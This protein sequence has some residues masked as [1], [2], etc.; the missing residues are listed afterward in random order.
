MTYLALYRAWRPQLFDDVIG[1]EHINQTLRNALREQRF[2]HAYLFNGPRGT[3]KTSTAKIFA[4]AVN[5]ELGPREEPCNQCNTCKGITD[6]SIMDVVEIDAAS[7][8]G[9]EEIR[10]L[11]EKVKFAPTEV[12]YKVY[13]IDEV[14]M[15]TTEA[16]NALLKTLEE[17]PAHVI[18]I[19]ATTEPH[20]LPLTIISRCQRFDFR[21]ISLE[22]IAERLTY[23]AGVEGFDV[24][25]DAITLVAKHSE[26][27]MRD[28]LSLL[29]QVL[30]FSGNKIET[31]DVLRVTGRVSQQ[32][33]SQLVS[34]IYEGNLELTLNTISEFVKQGKEPEKILEDMLY[35]YRDLLL[36]KSAPELEEIK[37]KV[38]ADPDFAVIAKQYDEGYIYQIIET[39]NH[40]LNEMKYASQPRILL[41]LAIIK[42]ANSKIKEDNSNELPS[43]DEMNEL[44][45]RL[46]E[47]EGK[48]VQ[49]SNN[50]PNAISNQAEKEVPKQKKIIKSSGNQQVIK[51]L[52][53]LNNQFSK[54]EL[55]RITSLWPD[56]LQEVKREK[57]TVHAWLVDGEPVAVSEQHIVIAFKNVMHRDTTD[58]PNHRKIIE[59]IILKHLGHDYQMFNIMQKDWRNFTEQTEQSKVKEEEPVED[60][61]DDIVTKA[62]EMFGEDLVEIKD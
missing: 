17:P 39:F 6:G 33:F 59:E 28:A 26:G 56:I 51:Q 9:V 60:K 35:F 14:H 46:K 21:R 53:Q 45:A 5:C 23:I 36:Y 32:I 4:K 13:I 10:D 61:E 7:N 12:K 44:K 41:E 50:S 52:N 27:G 38:I 29:D 58:K 57:I 49:L 15:L 20:K 43:N 40:F 55:K 11:R 54:S 18:F 8:R 3:G 19:L 22:K 31:E 25:E 47:L 1:Q 2:S 37:D 42:I 62:I 48:I 30:S 24:D 34:W 16:F